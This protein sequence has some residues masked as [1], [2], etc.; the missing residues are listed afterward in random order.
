MQNVKVARSKVNFEALDA[1]L[2]GALSEAYVGAS[3]GPQGVIAHLTNEASLQELA[4]AEQIITN[5]DETVLTSEQQAKADR[6][7]AL[8]SARAANSEAID[9]AAYAGEVALIQTLAEKMS[10][11]EVIGKI[12]FRM[13]DWVSRK[14]GGNQRLN[15]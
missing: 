8:E 2:R 10:E 7:A 14:I 1:E 15:Q 13:D 4:L 9:T 11:P 12:N 5:H 3:V 6:E